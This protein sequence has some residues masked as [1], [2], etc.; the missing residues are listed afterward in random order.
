MCLEKKKKQ[1][2]CLVFSFTAPRLTPWLPLPL[3]RWREV[4]RPLARNNRRA[5]MGLILIYRRPSAPRFPSLALGFG[6]VLWPCCAVGCSR[7]QLTSP[8][9][10][11][12][13]FRK[14][15][16]K[17][18]ERKKERKTKE[19]PRDPPV[20]LDGRYSQVAIVGN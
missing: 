19:H 4:R 8:C 6:F 2:G 20:V 10:Y 5:F 14:E 16:Q 1:R 13:I 18:K 11:H 3:A 7:F 17:Q 12:P 9:I 15:A